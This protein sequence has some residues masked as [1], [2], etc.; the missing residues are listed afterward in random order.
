MDNETPLI[1]AANGGHFEVVKFLI[2]N[3]AKVD[4]RNVHNKSAADVA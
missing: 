4:I 1:I 3:G 2:E